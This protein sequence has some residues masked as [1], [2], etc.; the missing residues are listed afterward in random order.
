MI[1]FNK[2][3]RLLY[4]PWFVDTVAFYFVS[5]VFLWTLL[6]YMPWIL[7]CH[8]VCYAIAL[9]PYTIIVCSNAIKTTPHNHCAYFMRHNLFGKGSEAMCQMGIG[10]C[11]HTLHSITI[12]K[13][14]CFAF[15]LWRQGL[16]IISG[17]TFTHI[18]QEFHISAAIIY[19]E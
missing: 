17:D 8:P 1:L 15:L 18:R 16:C 2:I 6:P 14:L 4:I 13:L 19:P 3:I 12:C 11:V 10:N 9:T 5:S 7:H